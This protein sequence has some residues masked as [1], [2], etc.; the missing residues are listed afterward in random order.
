MSI[1]KLRP[2]YLNL[3]ADER[4]VKGVE[5]ADAQNVRVGEVDGQDGGVIKTVEGNTAISPKTAADTLPATGDNKTVGVCEAPHVGF[6]YFMNHNSLGNHGVYRYDV[7]TNKYESVLVSTLLDVTESDFVKMDLI[8]QQNEDHFLFW[9]T[10]RGEPRRINVGTAM[11]G[12]YSNVTSFDSETMLAAVPPFRAPVAQYESDESIPFNRLKNVIVQFCAAHRYEDGDVSALGPISNAAVSETNMKF[13]LNVRSVES[14]DNCIRVTMNDTVTGAEETIIYARYAN[15]GPWY[16][17]GRV[18]GAEI[19]DFKFANDGVYTILSQEEQNKLYN[20]V[21]RSAK[22]Q[23]VQD[24]RLLFGNYIEGYSAPNVA[25]EVHAVY[26]QAPELPTIQTNVDDSTSYDDDINQDDVDLQT[27]QIVRSIFNQEFIVGDGSI[28]GTQD[29][30]LGPDE[31]AF[32][33][34]LNDI[35]N[36][37]DIDTELNVKVGLG[38]QQFGIGQFNRDNGGPISKDDARFIINLSDTDTDGLNP[39]DEF[40]FAILNPREVG[41]IESAA[42]FRQFNQLS[43]LAPTNTLEFNELITIP[44]AN[45]IQ[46]Y[47]QNFLQAMIGS[48]ATVGVLPKGWTGEPEGHNFTTLAK[49]V[50]FAS[51]GDVDLRNVDGESHITLWMGGNVEWEIFSGSVVTTDNGVD[52]RFRFRISSVDLSVL[53]SAIRPDDNEVL[54][55]QFQISPDSASYNIGERRLIKGSI[56]SDT[57]N[58]MSGGG[59]NVPN[60]TIRE[61]DFGVD[62]SGDFSSPASDAAHRH[63]MRSAAIGLS[64]L[65]TEVDFVGALASSGPTYKSGMTHN[66][67]I[68]YRDFAGRPCGVQ[69]IDSVFSE[70]TGAEARNGAQGKVEVDLQLS[71]PAPDWAR[72]YSIVYREGAEIERS[73]QYLISEAAYGGRTDFVDIRSNGGTLTRPIITGSQDPQS[74]KLYLSMRS[75]EGKDNSYKELK[76]GRV[77]YQY[78]EG[79]YLRVMS[80]VDESGTVQ[81]P[82]ISIPITG[83]EYFVDN[84]ENPIQVANLQSD[85]TD[86]YRRTGWFL[87]V[88]DPNVGGFSISSIASNTDNFSQRCVIEIVRPGKVREDAVWYEIHSEACVLGSFSSAI[89]TAETVQPISR[90]QAVVTF[91]D[92]RWRVGDEI[93]VTGLTDSGVSIVTDIQPQLDET[94]IV[95]VGGGL[96]NLF[97][98][99]ALNISVLNVIGSPAGTLGISLSNTGN[100]YFRVR[101]QLASSRLVA[102]EDLDFQL[103]RFNPADIDGQTYINIMV[104]DDH[105]SDFF[106]SNIYSYG[107][108]YLKLED[109][110]EVRRSASVTY[111][112]V[113]AFDLQGIKYH[114]FNPALFPYK[115]YQVQNGAIEFIESSNEA[116]RVYQ[117]NK[118]SNT[119]VNRQLI[120][121][122]SGGQLVT[123]S[124]VLG[125]EVY[126]A[127][128]FGPVDHPESV[129]SHMGRSYFIDKQRGKVVAVTSGG[130]TPISEKNVDSFFESA[131]EQLR[132]MGSAVDLPTGYDFENDEV[133]FTLNGRDLTDIIADGETIAT[134]ALTSGGGQILTD[135]EMVRPPVRPWEDETFDWEDVPVDFDDHCNGLLVL[136]EA[137]VSPALVLGDILPLSTVVVITSDGEYMGTTTWNSTL[138]LFNIPSTMLESDGTTDTLTYTASSNTRTERTA[139]YAA[140]SDVWLTFYDMTPERWAKI[141]SKL[142]SFKGGAPWLHNSNALHGSFYGTEYDASLKVVSKINPSMV[143]NYKSI[144]LE[145]DSAWDVGVTNTEQSTSIAAADFTEREGMHYAAM[146]KDTTASSTL[147]TSNIVV[148]SKVASI[149]GNS[150]IFDTRVSNLPFGIGDSLYK[151][152]ASATTSLSATITAVED[153]VTLRVSDA[154]AFTVDDVVVAVSDA[155]INGDDI[156]DYY[157][158]IEL[159][160]TGTD[161]RELYAVNAVFAPSPLH[162][163]KVN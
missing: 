56:N 79:D 95:T 127:G 66:F 114:S 123:S 23:T 14:V 62:S 154:S 106:Q 156:R 40:G 149:S 126:Y 119:P 18:D 103:G 100:S 92:G 161:A 20:A 36:S 93:V 145:G 1:D 63:T 58:N 104:E 70:V 130:I 5:M 31:V 68:V 3:D 110:A 47:A 91:S 65:Y 162:N 85:E 132:E 147:N 61:Y 109:E 16:E 54:P 75:I 153:R 45:T 49:R 55:W 86:D 19:V 111:S 135:V 35:Q 53:T 12:G 64:N 113:T 163:E 116:L 37:P 10:G 67:G 7:R 105:A 42:E 69:E 38:M 134:V 28:S 11:N 33:V 15:F 57:L 30:N 99:S 121:S 81:R 72:S 148:L 83:Y 34:S 138:G 6:V 96:D 146:P 94:Y 60:L 117:Q 140:K 141:G 107:N 129:M 131:S 90:E 144:S 59:G 150:V 73:W 122:A 29:V 39:S 2:Q 71:T 139:A 125:T 8:V 78:Q 120:E 9:T 88:R 143:K 27:K 158:T 151:I 112:D 142:L 101:E 13:D 44:A 48:T 22:A 157:I 155:S 133:L 50:D 136:D 152:E 32:T 108:P 4:F 77:D 84:E 74:G 46:E 115:D 102:D 43:R 118:V 98:S 160:G 82:N 137:L 76:G 124:N 25:G 21:P 80:Y 87:E 24:G 128:E 17:V 41:S 52:I 51:G 97:N 89:V 159:T 26:N